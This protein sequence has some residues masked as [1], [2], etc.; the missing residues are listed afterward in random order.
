MHFSIPHTHPALAGHFPGRPV[1]P[2]VL[3]L[4]TVLAAARQQEEQQIQGVTQAKFISVLLPD[5]PCVITLSHSSQGL[6]FTC[7]VAD[8]MVATGLLRLADNLP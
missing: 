1:V 6:R 3:I 2:G 4:E 8:R 5:E 7:A